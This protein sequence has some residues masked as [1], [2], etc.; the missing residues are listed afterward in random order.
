MQISL[1]GSGAMAC[2]FAARMSGVAQVTVVDDWPE[3]IVAIRKRGILLEDS[4]GTRTIPVEADYPG[5]PRASAD[6]AII[7]AKSWQT[8]A[9]AAHLPRYL[10]PEALAISLQ[11]GIGNIEILGARTFPGATAEGA[12]LLGPGHVRAGGSGP[13]HIVAPGWVVEL[14]RSAGFECYGCKP[15]EAESLLWG[16]LVVSCGI[17]AL[18]ALLRVPNGEL[19]NRPNAADLMIRAAK[20]CAAVAHAKGI[21]LP[22]ADPAARVRDV[23]E[24]TAANKSSMLQDL[25]RGA[26]TECDTI[27]G[28]IIAEGRRAG[29]PTPV[30]EFLWQLVQAS[31]HHTRSDYR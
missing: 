29:I 9:V 27:N 10:S 16:K 5:T 14:F 8:A 17:N 28:A 19:L 13:T 1:F 12:T 7:L 25:L 6:L 30:N 3:G 26:Q 20:E 24:K 21:R 18:T 31:A 22:F 2:L 11:N 4:A 15:E 23:A